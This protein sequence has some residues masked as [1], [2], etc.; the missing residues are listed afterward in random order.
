MS[1]TDLFNICKERAKEHTMFY[2]YTNLESLLKI[3]SS[4][5]IRLTQLALVNDLEEDRRIDPIKR[6]KVFAACFSHHLDE[7]IPLWN[8]YSKDKY[9]LCMGLPNISFFENH[10]NYF[11]IEN[12]EIKRLQ[13]NNWDIRDACIVDIK[14]VDDPNKH[15]NYMDPLDTGDKIPYPINIGFIKRKAWSFEAETRARVYIESTQSL[16]TYLH[17]LESPGIYH[18]SINYIYCKL[19]D[20]DINRITITFNP[21]M[22][23]EL[24]D[25]VRL[26]VMAYLPD[27]NPNNFFNSILEN[28]IRI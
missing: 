3:L 4:R 7:S 19:N 12:D 11:F 25:V 15:V 6:N 9:G 2:H 18:P 10:D 28:K 14:Y 8:M 27:F 20:E 21:F 17:E 1:T 26:A 13:D 24:K 16:L 5:S 23:H 22:S